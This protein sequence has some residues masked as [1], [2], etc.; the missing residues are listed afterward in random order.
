MSEIQNS[1]F[2]ASAGTSSQSWRPSSPFDLVTPRPDDADDWARFP[3]GWPHLVALGRVGRDEFHGIRM[4]HLDGKLTMI[5]ETT[6][7][8]WEAKLRLE[9][10]Y[11]EFTVASQSRDHALVRKHSLQC[12]GRLTALEKDASTRRVQD[13]TS[14]PIQ[15]VEKVPDEDAET[16]PFPLCY[17][18]VSKGSADAGIFFLARRHAD[19]TVPF[20]PYESLSFLE[21][22]A[23][24]KT[25]A[26]RTLYKWTT[27]RDAH[28]E[29]ARELHNQACRRRGYPLPD[30]DVLT[31]P[32][33]PED[34]TNFHYG[35][36]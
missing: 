1:G 5:G 15:V 27:E 32:Q 6:A 7:D 19:G 18:H 2:S 29:L 33:E 23:S 9:H 36:R 3:P 20:D 26:V 35:P 4:R 16:F 8:L 30:R 13:P 25:R 14:S 11:I 24:A 21:P 34:D 22:V 31:P 12:W 10:L 17:P 28:F